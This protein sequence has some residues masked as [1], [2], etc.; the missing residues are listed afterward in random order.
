VDQGAI[1]LLFGLMYGFFVSRAIHVAAELGIADLL[2]DGST[3]IDQLA[4]ATGTHRPSLYRLLRMLAGYGVF[5]EHRDGQFELTPG[6][7]GLVGMK[8][9]ITRSRT[10]YPDLHIS[11]EDQIAEGDKVAT[12]WT[13]TMTHNGKRVTLK[14][15]TIDR[16]ENGMIVEA[17]RSM[18]MLS[19]LQQSGALEK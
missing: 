3:T 9:S 4:S 7:E 14:G 12:R 5:A 11:I 13:G 8:K 19:F 10:V 15:I 16:F 2:R 18:D 1:E 17:W 6:S